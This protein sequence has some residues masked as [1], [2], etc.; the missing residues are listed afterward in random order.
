MRRTSVPTLLTIALLLAGLFGGVWAR[1]ETTTQGAQEQPVNIR[2]TCIDNQVD[3]VNIRPW[4]AA[5]RR[6]QNQQLRWQLAGGGVASVRIQPKSD[7]SW[8]FASSPPLTV[9][10][11]GGGTVS[12]AITG[13]DGRYF[14]DIIADCGSGDTVIDPRMD[15]RP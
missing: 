3:D 10:A 11:G 12:G 8:P 9:N 13:Q 5:V 6:S 2:I 1:A 14:Y 7:S 15:V 4:I